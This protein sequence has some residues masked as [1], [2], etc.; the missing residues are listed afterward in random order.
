MSI[1]IYSITTDV[2][3][4]L[5][6]IHR[7]GDFHIQTSNM[8]ASLIYPQKYPCRMPSRS[9]KGQ[10]ADLLTNERQPMSDDACD[11]P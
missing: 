6:N 5:L 7:K 8:C 4:R 3:R 10:S 9:E 11:R 2:T 1:S